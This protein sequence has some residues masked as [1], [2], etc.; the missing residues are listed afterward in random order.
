[1]A[2]AGP[3]GHAPFKVAARSAAQYTPP[4]PITSLADVDSIENGG[5]P[6]VGRWSA[7]DHPGTRLGGRQAVWAFGAD[8]GGRAARQAVV[9]RVGYLTEGQLT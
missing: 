8:S 2:L 3:V 4:A 1:M 7:L 5:T 6:L 9:A